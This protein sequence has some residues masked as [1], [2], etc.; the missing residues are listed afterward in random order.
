MSQKSG[1]PRLLSHY[2]KFFAYHYFTL[3]LSTSVRHTVFLHGHWSDEYV[4]LEGFNFLT[5]LLSMF[6]N[7]QGF[8]TYRLEN[9]ADKE[10]HTRADTRTCIRILCEYIKQRTA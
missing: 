1:D 5:T 10:K 6:R 4:H 2:F 7:E 8:T 9:I 3:C